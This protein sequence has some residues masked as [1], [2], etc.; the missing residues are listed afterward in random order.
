MK[1][2]AM[3]EAAVKA[4]LDKVA[5]GYAKR[6]L[7]SLRAC[8]APDPDVVMYGTG[9]D[10]KRLGLAEIQAQAKRDW[11]QSEA[12]VLTYGWT[13]VSAA[14]SVAWVATDAAFNLKAGGQEMTLPARITFVLE[15]RGDKWLIV[16]AHFSL[17][18]AAQ[19][20]GD[21]FPTS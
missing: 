1:T 14:G 10:E 11:S 12:S 8:F 20:E 13:S 9:A 3:T 6:D 2:D 17:P 5:E 16:Q 19:A 21:S 18:A 4:V 7:E 15:R